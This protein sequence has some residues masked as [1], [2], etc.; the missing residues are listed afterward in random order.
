[1]FKFFRQIF[2]D[3]RK[4]SKRIP[5]E[6]VVR[7]VD[8][9]GQT[10]EGRSEDLSHKG[11]RLVFN[12][13][14]MAQLMGHREEVPLEI[15]LENGSPSVSASA[16][17]KWAY[18]TSEGSTVSGWQFVHVPVDGRRRLEAFLAQRGS[19]EKA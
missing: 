5:I 6:L 13:S 9:E 18:S 4:D 17:L 1:M 3:P 19:D 7:T 14:S 15:C 12:G 11:I 16:G 10:R 2:G 8:T